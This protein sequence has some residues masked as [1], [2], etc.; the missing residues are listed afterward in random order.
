VRGHELT[1]DDEDEPREEFTPPPKHVAADR[2]AT[3]AI[4]SAQSI[5]EGLAEAGVPDDDPV[6]IDRAGRRHSLAA[7]DR[8]LSSA[9]EAEAEES[10]GAADGEIS[11]GGPPPGGR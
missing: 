7:L 11:P 10:P 6:V 1:P 3:G 4:R 9:L 5:S 2:F 8:L